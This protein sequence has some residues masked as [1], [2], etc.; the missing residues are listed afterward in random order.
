[1]ESEPVQSLSYD[2]RCMASSLYASHTPEIKETIS[3]VSE[4]IDMEI[5]ERT[6]VKSKTKWELLL[7]L[8]SCGVTSDQHYVHY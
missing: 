2:Q 8:N 3:L 1:M 4:F 5:P 6:Q 7:Y